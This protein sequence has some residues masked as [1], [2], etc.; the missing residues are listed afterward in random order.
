MQNTGIFGFVAV[1]FSE[2]FVSL[3]SFFIKMIGIVD[4]G[5]TKTHWRFINRAGEEKDVFTGGLNPYMVDQRQ[6]RDC[7][8]KDLYPFI[9]NTKV[10]Y[11]FFYGSGCAREGKRTLLQ[12]ELE[13]FF[14]NADIQIESDLMGAALALCG[15]TAGWVSILGTGAA[16]CFYD[17]ERITEWVPSLGYVLGEEG[18]GAKIGARFLADY[19]TGA[20]PQELREEFEHLCPYPLPEVLEKVYHGSQTARFLGEMAVFSSGRWEHPYIREVVRAQFSEFFKRQILPYREK[21][22]SCCGLHIIGSIAYYGQ[23]L[24]KEVADRYGVRIEKVDQSPMPGLSDY[25]RPK[26]RELLRQADFIEEA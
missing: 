24:L 12:S 1:P 10:R 22:G 21:T 6:I 4:S 25:Y 17:G 20:M 2:P 7:L 15:Q 19:W 23:D 16:S 9:D 18:S 5:S 8:E 13:E 14:R 3:S 11:L 26:I